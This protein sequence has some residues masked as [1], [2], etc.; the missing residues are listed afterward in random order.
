MAA[1]LSTDRPYTRP[2]PGSAGSGPAS[3]ARPGCQ[4]RRLLRL[5]SARQQ[6]RIPHRR[7]PFQRHVRRVTLV[8]SEGALSSLPPGSILVYITTSDLTLA[9]E[10]A[11]NRGP[12]TG[13]REVHGA[14]QGKGKSAKLGNRLRSRRRWWRWWRGGWLYAQLYVSLIAHQLYVSLMAHGDGE[15][16]IQALIPPAIERL[17]NG[18]LGQIEEP[19]LLCKEDCR[20]GPGRAHRGRCIVR[21]PM[22]SRDRGARFLC[23]RPLT[24]PFP[25][26][27]FRFVLLL[28]LRNERKPIIDAMNAKQT[29][30]LESRVIFD[31]GTVPVV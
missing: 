5:R 25:P 18:E 15:W 2:R 20:A 11:G 22:R 23:H 7:L 17:N 26:R 30:E 3:W 31:L 27:G 14:E 24:F 4:T 19:G 21:D 16:G 9:A 28:W 29:V 12:R 13:I 6:C 1:A 8:P 10:I